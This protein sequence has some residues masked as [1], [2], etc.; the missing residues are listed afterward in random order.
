MRSSLIGWRKKSLTRVVRSRILY[1]YFSFW[2]EGGRQD[3]LAVYIKPMN[4]GSVLA[5]M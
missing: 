1:Y 2:G 4:S 5:N 3:Q